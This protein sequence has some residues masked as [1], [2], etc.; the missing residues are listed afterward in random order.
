MLAQKILFVVNSVGRN[1]SIQE[2]MLDL[3]KKE[4]SDAQLVLTQVNTFYKTAS[5]ASKHSLYVKPV[6]IELGLIH[7][8]LRE[9]N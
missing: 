3:V 1:P 7:C 8:D 5:N 9:G 2:E 6:H 4:S